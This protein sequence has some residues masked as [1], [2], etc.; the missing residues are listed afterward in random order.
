[1]ATVLVTGAGRGL[2]RE[3]A[4]QYAADG[5]T[6]IA[7]A[8]QPEKAA[9]PGIEVHRL[10]VTDAAGVD[11][12]AAR[13]RGRAIDLLIN[14]AGINPPRDGQGVESMDFAAWSET[15]AVNVLA[16]FRLLQAVL[17]NLRAAKG[18][19]A[20]TIT[21]RMGSLTEMSAGAIAYRV[22]KAAVNAAMKGAALDAATRGIIVANYHP[23]WVKTDM[24]G[25]NA[26][27][28]IKDSI[29]SL[30][31]AFARLTPAD[32]GG[33]FDHDGSRIPW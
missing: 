25:P 17:P 15:M 3:F 21:S 26:T 23:G 1:M 14:N 24:G 33:F 5:W 11:A 22:S 20:I 18:A 16:P 28:T 29:A 7:T 12:L 2:G 6:V 8:R 4:R 19:K 31:A 30:R 13:L 32:T 9:G 10:A 27:L